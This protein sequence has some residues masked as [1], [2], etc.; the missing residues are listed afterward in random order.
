MKR[1]LIKNANIL[2]MDPAVGDFDDA[3]ILIE[4]G[5]IVATCWVRSTSCATA[6]PPSS[7][8]ATSCATPP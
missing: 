8:G 4:D 3:D 5:T 1:L 2:S 6:P 7:T